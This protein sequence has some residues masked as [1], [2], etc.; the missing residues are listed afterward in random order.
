MTA[1]I[2]T[3]DL[4]KVYEP[5]KGWRRLPPSPAAV[6]GVTL[7]VARG[8]L[9]G[10]LGPNGAGKTTLV[11]MLATLI[12]PS[13]GSAV[14]A[15]HPLSDGAA[16]RAAVGLVAS[17]ERSFYWRLSA[18][19]NLLFFAALHNLH[20]Q[21]AAER[22]DRALAATGLE[23][24]AGR[25]FAHLSSG[26]RQ[27]LAIAR[28]LLHRPRLLFLDE[29][30]RSLDPTATAQ[31]HALIRRLMAE[32]DL[33]ILLIT[34]DLSEA[35]AL[36]DRVALMHLGQLRAIGRPAD[37]RREL[38]SQREYT[39]AVAALA[40]AALAAAQVAAPGL[41]IAS[42]APQRLTFQS[43]EEDGRLNAVLT[44][45]HLHGA[46]V[47]AVDVTRPTL[48]EVF[49]HYTDAMP[50]F[51]PATLAESAGPAVDGN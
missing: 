36:C 19:R 42:G 8:E 11:K 6:A 1:I 14:V 37:L 51:T 40:P 32:E 39:L 34:H 28:S 9:F 20:G 18:R 44:A 15:G 4:A 16:I 49:A 12:S 22:V 43:S 10:L 24:E 29:P 31:L 3:H 38:Q 23:D 13:A 17:D 26:M 47:R 41:V 46:T 48:E 50:T 30:S 25:R 7:S 27:R 35:E 5:R 45:L 21:E 33:S 2:E